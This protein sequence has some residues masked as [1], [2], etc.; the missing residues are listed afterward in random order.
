MK[1]HEIRLAEQA[2]QAHLLA[3]NVEPSILHKGIGKENANAEGRGAHRHLP[4]DVAKTHETQ[5]PARQAEHGLPWRKLPPAAAYEPVVRGDFAGAYEY[6]SHGVLG[7]FLDAVGRV[8]G[9][10]D[11]GLR[12]SVEVDGVLA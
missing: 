3:G 7:D 9:D 1:R 11:A 12:G 10:D 4:G 8:V 5:S 2:V 6:Q